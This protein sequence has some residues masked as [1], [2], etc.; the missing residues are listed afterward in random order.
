MNSKALKDVK[1]LDFT[2]YVSGPYCT[3]LLG[4]YGADVIKIERPITG[5]P[6]RHL[7]PFEE[8]RQSPQTGLLF[9]YLNTNKK[10]LEIDLKS[11]FGRN[12]VEQLAMDTDILVE[13]S[14]P[15]F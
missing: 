6:C 13:I 14:D 9:K 8:A 5:D 15:V 10:S 4:D 11:E 2:H 3:K 12:T 1:V 7:P